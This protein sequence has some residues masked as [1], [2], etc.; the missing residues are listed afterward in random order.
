MLKLGATSSPRASAECLINIVGARTVQSQ[1][2]NS[3]GAAEGRQKEHRSTTH[4]CAMRALR[5]Q[6]TVRALASCP[7][8]ATKSLL[9]V[10][11]TRGGSD[12]GLFFC[13]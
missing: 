8:E 13:L 3:E 5:S 1:F 4:P 11:K 10:L 2:P 7:S 12:L 9:T 6:A